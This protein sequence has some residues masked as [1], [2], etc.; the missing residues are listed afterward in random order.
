MELVG[1]H[2]VALLTDFYELTMSASYFQHGMH[3]QATFEL[4]ARRLPERRNFLLA[5]GTEDAVDFLEGLRFDDDDIAYLRTLGVFDEEFL[6]HLGDLRFSGD[7]WG[8]RE[9]ELFFPG[10]PVLR[11]RAPVIEG[12]VVETFLLTCIGFQSLVASKAARIALA[13]GDSSFV[14]F[15]PR[16]DHG[17]DAALWAARASYIAGAVAT[18]NVL[19][20][21]VFGIPLSGT[22]AHSY[23]MSF[24]QEAD[25]FRCFLETFPRGTTLLIDTYDTLEGARRAAAVV[26]E[27]GERVQLRAVR[28]DSGDLAALSRGVRA[29][30]DKAGLRDVQIFASGDLDEYRI[31]ELRRAGAPVDA[32]GAGTQLGTGGD[33]PALGMVYKLVA[34]EGGPKMKRS[35][36]KATL[37]GPKQ[38]YRF[39]R[40]GQVQ[41]DLM[42]MAGEAAPPGGRA[43]LEP[44]L[45]EGRRLRQR[46]PI[47]AA[48]ER[49][50][51]ALASLPDR[52][53]ALDAVEPAYEVRQSPELQRLA[54]W[55]APH[56]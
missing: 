25:S 31:A 27:M 15:S 33:V 45:R 56:A 10:E 24:E 8:L 35:T 23:V 7:A 17:P 4:F 20:G 44:L 36:G 40:A 19:A 12:Q 49:A 2:D 26:R 34:D 42:A 1:P 47:A 22:M 55:S 3:G 54:S 46:E 29:I 13:C 53:R 41:Y 18:S 38:V 52:L 11:V 9:G 39:E 28:L 6:A 5:C 32:Y 50:A 14:D 21:R 37:P 16:R 30:L 51:A 48:K 43:L